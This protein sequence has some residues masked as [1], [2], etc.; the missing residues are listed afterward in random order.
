MNNLLTLYA[1]LKDGRN[2][3][4]ICRLKSNARQCCDLAGELGLKNIQKELARIIR[5]GHGSTMQDASKLAHEVYTEA[6]DEL[7]ENIEE[8]EN[9][10]PCCGAPIKWTDICS[11]CLEHI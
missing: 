2:L 11:E 8:L 4:S 1:L 6:L 9:K 3:D 10:S 5:I 7:Y